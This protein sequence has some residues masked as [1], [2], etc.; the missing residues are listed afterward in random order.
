M[1]GNNQKATEEHTYVTCAK[2]EPRDGAGRD[3]YWK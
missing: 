3:M 1:F 2:D